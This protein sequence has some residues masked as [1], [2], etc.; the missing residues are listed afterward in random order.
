MVMVK[1]AGVGQFGPT[2]EAALSQGLT[3]EQIAAVVEHFQANPGRWAAGVLVERL[4]RPGARLLAPSEGWYGETR[5]W[6]TAQATRPATTPAPVGDLQR[7]E[8]QLGPQLDA[9]TADE[10]ASLVADWTP[11]QRRDLDFHGRRHKDLRPLLLAAL[12]QLLNQ[13]GQP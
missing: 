1:N 9:L 13:K 6:K 8:D 11:R 7:L 4:T 5:E 3:I 2:V 10:L 12:L